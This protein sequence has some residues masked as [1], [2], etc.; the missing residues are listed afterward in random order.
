MASTSISQAAVSTSVSRT[1]GIA[2]PATI[3]ATHYLWAIT[4][5]CMGW[6]FLWPFLDK[7]FGLGHETS[8]AH[9]WIR[10]G[11][12]SEGFLSGSVGPLSSF[13]QSL[14]GAGLVN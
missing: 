4:W 3:Q 1:T 11:S 9:A 5:L 6:V 14:A 7:T 8:L 2:E 10:G 13:Y 12:P